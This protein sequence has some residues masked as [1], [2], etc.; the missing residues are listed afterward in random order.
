MNSNSSV[1]IL[2]TILFFMIFVLIILAIIF[3]VLKF[4]EKSNKNKRKSEFAK[5]TNKKSKE[6]KKEELIKEYAKES[7][8]S[9]MD[10]D[11]VEDNMIIKKEKKNYL[12]VIECPGI[13]YDLM[14]GIEKTSV[15]QGFLQFLNTLRHPI[16]IYTQTRTVNLGSSIST[17]K[18]KL[19]EIQD[20]LVKTEL[21][22]RQKEN[23]K[24]YSEEELAKLKLE[25][26]KQRNLYEY[27]RDIIKNTEQMSLN[28]S[29][30]TKQYYIIISY[31]AE[32]LDSKYDKEEVKNLAFSELYTKAQSIISAL[33]VCGINAKVLNSTE[34]VELLYIA[35]NRDES[36]TYDLNKMLNAGYEELYSTAPNVLDKKMKELDQKIEE[37]AIRKANDAVFM[38]SE[39]NEKEKE[40]REKERRLDELI[41]DM[42]KIIV[43][44]NEGFLG[45]D[46]TEKAKEIIDRDSKK[47]GGN[48]DE[49]KASKGRKT[50]SV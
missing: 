29:I 32:D 40:V 27:G 13:N 44:E 3:V 19:K 43:D 28:K 34:L 46:I 9:F 33:F 31:Y 8:F 15:E 48:V 12:M 30:L 24:K 45:R 7:V 37:E 4:K 35:Y 50:K 20:R 38:A 23:S 5:E 39:E 18:G 2:T 47:E 10:F 25:V 42:A 14:S 6:K 36:E 17:Y 1:G 16:Q 11:K 26:V 22:Y 49:K 41:D 21:D